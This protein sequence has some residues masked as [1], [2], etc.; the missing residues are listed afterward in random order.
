MLFMLVSVCCSVQSQFHYHGAVE[1]GLV[2]GNW[3]TNSYV[4]T[5]HGIRY[6]QWLFG[7]GA[8]IDY[9]RYRSVPVYVEVQRSFGKKTVRPFVV[10]A[11]GVNTTWPTEEQKQ[12]WNGWLQRTPAIFSNGLYSRLGAGVLLNARAK[13]TF[14]LRAAYSYKA[15]SRS[16][17]EF[18]WDPWPQPTNITEKEMEYRLNRLTIG[19]GVSF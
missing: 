19:L 18:T 8:G 5:T 7:L 2:N 13:V 9:Y 17:T 15:L 16:Y 11:A 12:E 14:S 10:A 4:Q 3:E 6:K 1:A